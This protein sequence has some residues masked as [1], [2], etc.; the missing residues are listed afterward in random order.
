MAAYLCITLA[1][2]GATS[3]QEG[4]TFCHAFDLTKRLENSAIQGSLR[5]TPIS[6]APGRLPQQSYFKRFLA[7]V[8]ASIRTS[9]PSTIHRIVVPNL[10]SP[11]IYPPSACRPQEVLQFLHS[12]RGLLRQFP[13]QAT[14]MLSLPVSLYPRAT[15]LTRWA[16]LLA[17]GVLELIPLQHQSQMSREPGK[18]EKSQGLL[19]AHSL[20]V[21]HEKGGALEGSWSREDLSFKLSASSGMVITPFALPPV[22][23]EEESKASTPAEGK[24]ESLEF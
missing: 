23:E 3:S 15:G 24:K 6:G 12:L 17:D 8:A 21:F 5:A 4:P 20:P 9:P 10:L 19:R 16:E 13:S 22:G 11:T 1:T 14:A 2:P 7:D 18:E